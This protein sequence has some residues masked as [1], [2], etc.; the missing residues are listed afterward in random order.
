MAELAHGVEK[1][2]DTPRAG[3]EACLR[4]LA[5]AIGMA[6]A[7]GDAGFAQFA[8]LLCGDLLGRHRYQQRADRFL[9]RNEAL[10]TSL[11]FDR[12]HELGKMR[13]LARRRQM[14]TFEMQTRYAAVRLDRFL[15]RLDR[16]RGRVRR[17]GDQRR[18]QR[19]R[20][21]G[22]MTIGDHVHGGCGRLVVEHSA[23]AAIH[24]R[25]D[26]ACRKHAA[27]ERVC[28]ALRQFACRSQWPRRAR[29]TTTSALSSWKRWPSKIRAPEKILRTITWSP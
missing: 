10:S 28:L 7:D 27:F 12:A 15:R 19:G 29:P 18:Q 20:T 23:A 1:M 14:R 25:I 24:L 11:V 13:A 21:I 6:N 16:R 5:G 9:G 4:R 26:E 3:V 17:V 8:Y 2:G 22:P